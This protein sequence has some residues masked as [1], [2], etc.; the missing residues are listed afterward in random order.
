LK[1]ISEPLQS[2]RA[3]AESGARNRFEVAMRSGLTALVGREDESGLLLR[4]WEH[5]QAG[6]GRVVLLSGEPGIGKSRLIRELQQRIASNGATQI[7]FQ[8]SPYDQNSALYPIIQH[9]D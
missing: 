8:F 2:F 4:Q 7:E 9:L 5:A 1:G 3:I 6:H